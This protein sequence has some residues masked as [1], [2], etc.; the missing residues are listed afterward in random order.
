MAILATITYGEP[1]GMV[2]FESQAG[3]LALEYPA[4]WAALEM[5]E[6][7]ITIMNEM[8]LDYT[9]SSGQ[10][11]VNIATP[12]TVEWYLQ[13]GIGLPEDPTEAMA[14]FWTSVEEKELG[15]V[16]DVTVGDYT[17]TRLDFTAAETEEGY[18][19]LLDVDGG[20]LA[21]QVTAAAGELTDFDAEVTAI[22]ESIVYTPVEGTQE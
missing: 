5:T 6:G 18:V 20:A 11:V 4:G 19:L 22:L 14:S 8:S 2:E 12:S 7:N 3:D 13:E 16:S 1:G 9:L 10:V 21:V 17:G 15:E